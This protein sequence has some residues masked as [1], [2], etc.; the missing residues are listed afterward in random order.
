MTTLGGDDVI[1][2]NRAAVTGTT[3]VKAGAGADLLN[4]T[5]PAT[6]TGATTIDLG[7]GD[8]KWS[9][10]SS[11]VTTAGPVTFTGRVNAKLGTGNDTLVLGL[12]VGSGGN[13]NTVAAFVASSGNKIDGGSGS[14][15]FNQPAAQVTGI[16]DTVNFE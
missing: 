8:D 1:R 4:M 6:F 10:A 16:V 7:A 5:G 9:I 12:V 3:N 15:S 14:D 2:L 13:L 11:V